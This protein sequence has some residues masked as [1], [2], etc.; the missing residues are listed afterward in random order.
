MI[1]SIL[2]FNAITPVHNGAGE[3]LGVID[4]PIM[5]ERTTNYLIIQG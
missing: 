4:R 1:H 3:G 5:R 2:F